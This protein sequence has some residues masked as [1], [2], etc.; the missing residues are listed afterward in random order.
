MHHARLHLPEALVCHAPCARMFFHA[1]LSPTRP[2][3]H[4]GMLINDAVPGPDKAIEDD[5][6]WEAEMAKA[7]QV[8]NV[9]VG[10]GLFRK[11]AGAGVEHSLA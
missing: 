9:E 11:K 8:A 5:K 10:V 4:A 3:V 6:V 1:M 7:S 2:S